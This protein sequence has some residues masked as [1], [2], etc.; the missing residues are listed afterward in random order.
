MAPR[1]RLFSLGFMFK[2]PDAQFVQS[3]CGS[4]SDDMEEFLL[5]SVDTIILCSS[6][7]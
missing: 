7:A 4:F 3:C 5:S 6:E 2:I 1:H